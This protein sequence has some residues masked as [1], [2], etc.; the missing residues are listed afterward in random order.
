VI[1]DLRKRFASLFSMLFFRMR[2][3]SSA[4]CLPHAF[5]P[6]ARTPGRSRQMYVTVPFCDRHGATIAGETMIFN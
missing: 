2:N 1:F 3:A 5:P 4:L 6:Q